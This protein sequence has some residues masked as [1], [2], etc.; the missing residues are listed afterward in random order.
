MSTTVR[1]GSWGQAFCTP[2][3]FHVGGIPEP[4]PH[5]LYPTPA[6]VANPGFASHPSAEAALGGL[7]KRTRICLI[8]ESEETWNEFKAGEIAS[9]QQHVSP[10]TPVQTSRKERKHALLRGF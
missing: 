4:T 1:Q 2:C 6:A 7:I 3:I 5:H 9:L 10:T 8:G